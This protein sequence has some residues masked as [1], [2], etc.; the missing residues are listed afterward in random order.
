MSSSV[1]F[2]D[3]SHYIHYDVLKYLS[4]QD[5]L[6]QQR[7][8][9]QWRDAIKLAFRDYRTLIFEQEIS[10][11]RF[12]MNE[13]VDCGHRSDVFTLR[14]HDKI[15][16]EFLNWNPSAN[17]PKLNTFA[18]DQCPELTEQLLKNFPKSIEHLYIGYNSNEA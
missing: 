5:Q 17:L 11:C 2:C 9:K 10:K 1:K 14:I 15:I 13:F 4:F 6:K 7:V 8:N 12:H 3:L 18:M 16:P